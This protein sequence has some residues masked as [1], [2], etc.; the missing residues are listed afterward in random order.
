MDF[1]SPSSFLSPSVNENMGRANKQIAVNMV[2]KKAIEQKAD[3]KKGSLL[4]RWNGKH[5]SS[6]NTSLCNGSPCETCQEHWLEGAGVS[7]LNF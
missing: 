5:I 4:E 7:F 2:L 1:Y 3:K 6:T